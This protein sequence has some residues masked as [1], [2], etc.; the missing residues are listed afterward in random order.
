MYGRIPRGRLYEHIASH[1]EELIAAGKLT[2][3]DQLPAERELARQMQVGRGA[4]RESVKLLAERGL[5]EILPGR[6]TFVAEP[7]VYALAVHL[8]RFL[9]IGPVSYDDLHEVRRV[10]EVATA[11]L[12]AQ[13]AG[14]EDLENLRVVI[15]QMDENLQSPADYVE[16]HLSFHRCLAEATGNRIF[17]FLIDVLVELIRERTLELFHVP[18]APERRQLWH[19]RIYNAIANHDVTAARNAMEQHLGQGLAD[20]ELRTAA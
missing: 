12:A 4:I 18:G 3:G 19:H 2:P 17:P 20:E 8:D 14:E 5:V 11:G 9:R 6:G 10:L 16:A 15:A 13:R 1:I 7:D